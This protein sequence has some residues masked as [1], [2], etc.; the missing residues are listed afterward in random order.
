MFYV[1]LSKCIALRKFWFFIP[2]FSAIISGKTNIVWPGLNAPIL[3]GKELVVQRELP[4]DA[5][6]EA[7]ILKLRDSMGLFRPLRLSPLERG[8]SGTKMHGRSIGPPDSIGQDTFDG[9]DT[10]VL[11]VMMR[12]K[13]RYFA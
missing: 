3:Q 13:S 4:P 11:E 9:F 8:W 10:K 7:K 5:E 6:R 1:V 2:C 12:D